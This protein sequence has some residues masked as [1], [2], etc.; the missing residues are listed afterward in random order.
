MSNI[1]LRSTRPVRLQLLRNPSSYGNS[2][3]S[4]RVPQPGSLRTQHQNPQR[5]SL[6]RT[7]LIFQQKTK[8]KLM[9]ESTNLRSVCEI[10]L[11]YTREIHRKTTP[12]DPNFLRVSVACGKIEQFI[13]GV[14]PA[15]TT[16]SVQQ[17]RLQAEREQRAAGEP[18]MTAEDK[19]ELYWIYGA[20][21]AMWIVLFGI[22]AFI[23]WLFGARFDLLFVDVKR[24]ITNIFQGGDAVKEVMEETPGRVE[25]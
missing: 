21:V 8:L 6:S 16:P 4:P 12:T 15:S 9:M 19:A 3:T 23:A 17:M 25:L 18:E 22:M 13:E 11:K 1:P 10:F 20:I 5:R 7:T 24:T 2:D 14:F